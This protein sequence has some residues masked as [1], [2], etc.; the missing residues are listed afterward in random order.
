MEDHEEFEEILY[1]WDVHNGPAIYSQL[2]YSVVLE[3]W[4]DDHAL[5]VMASTAYNYRRGLPRVIEFFAG[6]V[7]QNVT[8][9]MV[10]ACRDK[11]AKEFKTKSSINLYCK[12]ISLSIKYA[13]RRGY[14]YYN[15]IAEL[16]L[17]KHYRARIKP[18]LESEIPKLL[19]QKCPQWVT[20]A[21]VIAFFS[22]MRKGEIFALKWSDINLDVGYIMVQSAISMASSKAEIKCPKTPEGVRRVDTGSAL[23]DYLR[24][25]ERR[26]RQAGN[27]Y[28]F[29]ASKRGKYPFRIPWNIA[30]IVK[31]M[32]AKAGI[33]PRDF[34]SLRHSHA[35]VLLSHGVHPKVVQE[36]L[37]H[38]DFD[39]T[40]E[41][42]SFV[43][44]TIQREAAQVMD[45][46]HVF[47]VVWAA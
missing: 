47:P 37:G 39:I 22:G 23:K 46:L 18:F 5:H 4:A 32:C 28:V 26:A 43:A 29:P 41:F 34:R 44:P 33:E 42:Y 7:V 13:L 16:T 3:E 35:T 19:S 21:I 1:D 17:T 15:P 25:M 14:I 12:I 36:R 40:M 20:D 9:E 30:K 10:V 6:V 45:D 38:T 24:V 31:E 2:L 8:A 11:L 27:P